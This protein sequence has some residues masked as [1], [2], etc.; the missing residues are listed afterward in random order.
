MGEIWRITNTFIQELDRW[1]S[2][3]TR[4][5]M[6]ATTNMANSIDYAIRR[7][8][9]SEVQIPLPTTAELSKMAG[10]PIPEGTNMSHATMRKCILMARRTQVLKG[11]DYTTGLMAF[12]AGN[13]R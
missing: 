2:A 10:V 9:E 5:L 3:P 12:V 13:S 1:H 6:I 4:S 11:I 7:R 8:F